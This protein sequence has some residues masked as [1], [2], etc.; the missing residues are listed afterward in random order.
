MTATVLTLKQKN[1]QKIANEI[2]TK[3]IKTFLDIVVLR[4][5]EKQP[6]T[7]PELIRNIRKKYGLIIRTDTLYVTVYSL[8]GHKII[9]KNKIDG[10]NYYNL[11]ERGVS[12]LKALQASYDK[13]KDMVALIFKY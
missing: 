3:L 4:L 10:K 12:Q 9:D 7:P 13:T 5:L 2:N 11:T 6:Q 1:T 8:Y